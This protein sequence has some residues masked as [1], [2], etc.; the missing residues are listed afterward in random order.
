MCLF[1]YA[2]LFLSLADLRQNGDCDCRKADC[3]EN[4]KHHECKRHSKFLQSDRYN[5]WRKPGNNQKEASFYA[6]HITHPTQRLSADI[7]AAWRIIAAN[8]AIKM[9]FCGETEANDQGSSRRAI[10]RTRRFAS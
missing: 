1:V 4:P 2:V 6:I 10:L 8:Q 3:A 7:S 5:P 9:L